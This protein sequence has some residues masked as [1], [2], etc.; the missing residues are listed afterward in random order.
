VTIRIL[1]ADNH[2]GM[3]ESMRTMIDRQTD[4]AVVTEA[5]DGKAALRL[6]ADFK[7]DVVIMDINMSD[8]KGVDAARQIISNAPGVKFLA[9]SMHA[10]LQFVDE[11]IKA[12]ACGYLLKDQ[13]FEELV[14]AIR[15][16]VD[17]G[18]YLCPGV[19]NPASPE[20]G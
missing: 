18:I 4:M 2:A 12:G 13:A 11:M 16:V 10:N 5:H 9:L 8:L 7:P 19:E 15:I 6:V 14:R 3:R 1:L 20:S 17:D